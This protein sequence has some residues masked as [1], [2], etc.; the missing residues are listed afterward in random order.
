VNDLP[1][2]LDAGWGAPQLATDVANGWQNYAI[3]PMGGP[4]R[5]VASDLNNNIYQGFT[6]GGASAASMNPDPPTGAFTALPCTRSGT[7]GSCIDKLGNPIAAGALNWESTVP[8]GAYG[9][10]TI[11]VDLDDETNLWLGQGGDDSTGHA[12]A[13][14]MN[15]LTGAPMASVDVGVG[16]LYSYSDFTGYG[17]RHITLSSASYN[18]TFYG[19]G[20]SPEFTV[21]T[22]LG[23]TDDIPAGTDISYT[24]TVTNANDPITLANAQPYVVC[25]SVVAGCG[26]GVPSAGGTIV[27]P[28]TLP[29]GKYMTVY[30]TLVPKVC[31]LGGG[32]VAKA[33]PT[34]YSLNTVQECAGD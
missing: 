3:P 12:T 17:L 7:G 30:A 25:A 14:R 19:C 27:L 16:G 13:V 1:I 6:V 5:G 26:Q 34:L 9:S 23:F 28:S 21:W 29:Q 32:G 10:G 18:Q 11:G 33:V 20:V 31:S 4:G 22:G 2:A 15:G 24:V 8:A